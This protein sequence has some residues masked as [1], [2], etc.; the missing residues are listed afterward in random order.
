M[1][2]DEKPGGE[3]RKGGEGGE[4]GEGE[5]WF[6]WMFCPKR[7]PKSVAPDYSD[8]QKWD[9]LQQILSLVNSKF[10]DLSWFAFHGVGQA[11]AS[12]PRAVL[13][14]VSR[15]LFSHKVSLLGSTP[16]AIR[17]F[18]AYV[19]I[20]RSLSGT[21][22][23][24]TSIGQI[25]AMQA[26][27]LAIV[28]GVGMLQ[29]LGSNMHTATRACIL[30][31]F[32]IEQNN[33]DIVLKENNQDRAGSLGG[34]LGGLVIVYFISTGWSA[35]SDTIVAA[36]IVSVVLSVLQTIFNLASAFVLRVPPA[37][38][39]LQ[40]CKTRKFVVLNHGSI[41]AAE[42]E[43]LAVFKLT[44]GEIRGKALVSVQGQFI[45]RDG[46]ITTV[47]TAVWVDES[48]KSLRL[49]GE[50]YFLT[51]WAGGGKSIPD[52]YFF[53]P[54]FPVSMPAGYDEDTAYD[55]LTGMIQAPEVLLLWLLRWKYVLGV[56]DD[57]KSPAYACMVTMY[58]SVADMLCG[59]ICG[60]PIFA[61]F[62]NCRYI[63]PSRIVEFFGSVLEM[64]AAV[65]PIHW[66]LALAPLARAMSTFSS[67]IQ[68]KVH[69]ERDRV[70]TADPQVDLVHLTVSR[71]N[72]CAV[73]HLISTALSV[74]YTWHLTLA[75][76][77]AGPSW[78]GILATFILVRLFKLAADCK[79]SQILQR[80]L[81]G[82]A[83]PQSY[84]L[85][86]RAN[87]QPQRSTEPLPRRQSFALTKFLMTLVLV[88]AEAALYAGLV[89]TLSSNT[90]QLEPCTE[91]CL[92]FKL[93]NDDTSIPG[94][95]LFPF[96]VQNGQDSSQ[97]AETCRR[98]GGYSCDRLPSI[99]ARSNPCE[100]R[101]VR[102][103]VE[104][105]L[106]GSKSKW[107]FVASIG[108][109]TVLNLCHDWG[110]QAEIIGPSDA[111]MLHV[112]ATL[113]MATMAAF[114]LMWAS[115]A[116]ELFFSPLGEEAG[117]PCGCYFR[118]ADVPSLVALALPLNLVGR[119][120]TNVTQVMHAAI[121]DSSF[122]RTVT[123]S[124]PYHFIAG[125]DLDH[126]A[127]GQSSLLGVAGLGSPTCTRVGRVWD[128]F[129]SKQRAKR[130]AQR[131]PLLAV[132]IILMPLLFSSSFLIYRVADLVLQM[133]R[134]LGVHIDQKSGTLGLFGIYSMI[135]LQAV[136][137]GYFMRDTWTLYSILAVQNKD[138]VPDDAFLER[139]AQAK[140]ELRWAF[141][142]SSPPRAHSR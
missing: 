4:G 51:P 102:R 79:R 121:I 133:M 43:D 36:S 52:G 107:A 86:P 34:V 92:Q 10:G 70:Y 94:T 122:L 80:V 132:G 48:G 91:R 56:G 113:T 58:L 108:V 33:G 20:F 5:G 135:A 49:R 12:V 123:F 53:P 16:M 13:F 130:W 68:S 55:L 78:E 50:D 99:C 9:T 101:A 27:S 14:T 28:W 8:F 106:G 124:V 111:V 84:E 38:F 65:L 120:K 104:D 112:L 21:L 44:T 59:L 141:D 115:G 32:A 139:L 138:W 103:Q 60:L 100:E 25:W 117:L 18:G 83:A 22:I 87:F 47:P 128:R 136:V 74:F 88:L 126:G 66:W 41:A 23:A 142:S 119:L 129:S 89:T 45:D 125:A 63:L 75:D 81:E 140:P 62:Y 98:F 76:Q 30:Q 116:M 2:F 61:D 7:W 93:W 54:G 42:G 24:L 35:H 134:G 40:H 72:R 26:N 64:V 110:L 19:K 105:R 1:G 127:L 67:V 46:R 137:V 29:A 118:L 77:S 6:R 39:A 73:L 85:L 3:G 114:A 97:L 15:D 96:E 82:H 109:Y 71:K 95:G 57:S 37:T 17:L 11:S 69:A 31:H 131:L 90:Q